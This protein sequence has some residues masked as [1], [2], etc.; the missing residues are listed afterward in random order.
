M[1]K[2][3]STNT[4]NFFLVL[5]MYFLL[6]FLLLMMCS[7]D[8]DKL[9]PYLRHLCFYCDLHKHQEK[10]K[11]SKL[12]GDEFLVFVLVFKYNL[13]RSLHLITDEWLNLSLAL[14]TTLLQASIITGRFLLATVFL[15]PLAFLSY[16][17][18][19]L[20]ELLHNLNI[21]MNVR[22]IPHQGCRPFVT[23]RKREILDA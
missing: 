23:G 19:S 12:T 18:R 22:N 16:N 11:A 17:Q 1:S 20:Q 9:Y 7:I 10:P 4:C 6:D 14:K 5:K 8:I 13:A 2:S 21:T 15:L 3:H